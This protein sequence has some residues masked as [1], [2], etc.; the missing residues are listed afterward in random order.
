MVSL[1][2]FQNGMTPL[3]WAIEGGHAFTVAL[4][5]DLGADIDAKSKASH[6]PHIVTPK[7]AHNSP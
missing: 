1:L 6:A 4:V 2:L 7:Q 5:L 3:H